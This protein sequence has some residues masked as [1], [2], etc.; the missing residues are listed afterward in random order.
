MT[1]FDLIINFLYQNLDSIGLILG[2]LT[3]LSVTYITV[4]KRTLRALI[5]PLVV[6]LVE[7]KR[8]DGDI[9]YQ[10]V[11]D[12]VMATLAR[13]SVKVD[14]KIIGTLV[15]SATKDVVKSI[16]KGKPIKL[17]DNA[18]E[19]EAKAN[20]IGVKATALGDRV[21]IGATTLFDTKTGKVHFQGGNVEIK[22]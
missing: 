12:A 19:I 8:K 14:S 11:L 17:I 13:N 4:I 1:T 7:E 6:R 21:R 22:F 15:K 18:V 20:A 9:S 16:N 10:D 2:A 5:L 3:G